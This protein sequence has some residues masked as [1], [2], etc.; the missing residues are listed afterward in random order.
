MVLT[1][2]LGQEG[3]TGEDV[4]TVQYLVTAQGHPT[5]VDGDFGPL[6]RAAVEAFQSSRGLGVDGI[7][8]P[9]T[10]P[11]LII[12]VQ[13]GSNGDTVRAV[14][15]Q[16]HSRGHGANQITI[17]GIFGPITNDA[18]RAFQT[19]LGLSVDGI[20]GPQTWNH[21]VN[22]YLAAPDPNTAAQGRHQAA[23]R[24][25]PD[26]ALDIF[27]QL[28]APLWADKVRWELSKLAERKPAD[29]LTETER[30]VAALIAQGHTNREVAAAMF[31]TENTVQTH[32]RHIFQ[33]LG[34][35]SRTELAV[36]L[37]STGT[38]TATAD[39]PSMTTESR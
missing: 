1:W 32:I 27:E 28:G 9:Q 24:A 38:S 21:L 10:W 16:I 11:Q 23:A 12:Q 39:M 2:P 30:H 36:R 8:G 7:V 29:R 26:Q 5:A 6:T 35:R 14:Q 4:R 19:L 17:D 15:S 37:L 20:V 22:G 25:A 33:K 13:Q 31:V 18:V 34:V 3:S